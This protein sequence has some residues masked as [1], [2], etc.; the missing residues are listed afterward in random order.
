[1]SPAL[2][3]I[4]AAGLER[5]ERDRSASAFELGAYTVFVR[6]PVPL[7]TEH[8]GLAAHLA[9]LDVAL[10]ASCGLINHRF[11]PLSTSRALKARI[12]W[13]IRSAKL[14]CICQTLPQRQTRS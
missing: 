2:Q 3:D 9:I 13:H 6:L 11:I 10:P 12:N 14:L 4:E 5:F 1:M 8:V 7:N